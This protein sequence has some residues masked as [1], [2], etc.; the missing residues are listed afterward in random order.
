MATLDHVARAGKLAKSL[1]AEDVQRGDVVAILDMVCE[2][3]SF[4]WSDDPHVLPPQEPVCV[5]WRSQHTKKPLKVKAICL[6]YILVKT[7]KGRHKT[8]DVRQ[9][10]LVRLSDDYAKKAWKQFRKAGKKHTS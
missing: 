1:A 6:P 8:L 9:C 4:L 5:R 7:P 2:Y 10:R 3:P